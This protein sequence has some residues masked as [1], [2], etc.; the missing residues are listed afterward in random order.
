MTLNG[1]EER[2]YSVRLG[3]CDIDLVFNIMCNILSAKDIRKHEVYFA[4]CQFEMLHK[5][6]QF[7][8]IVL[9]H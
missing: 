5:K 2:Y 8:F 1:E 9:F 7:K 4:L 6:G 3:Y